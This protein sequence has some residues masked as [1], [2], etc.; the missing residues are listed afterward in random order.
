A[1]PGTCDTHMHFYGAGYPKHPGTTAAAPEASVAEYR[2][3]MTWLDIDRVVVVQP[4]A[5]GFDN[6]CTLDSVA[7]LGLDKA[8][9]V[10]VVPPDVSEAELERL[11][12]AGAR[13]VGG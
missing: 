11:T 9:A 12:R 3:I 1:P 10:V 8:R 13:A 6:R 4:N 2:Q 7:E 5:Y